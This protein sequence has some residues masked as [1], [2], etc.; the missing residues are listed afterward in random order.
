MEKE[1]I[2]KE[3]HKQAVDQHFEESFMRMQHRQIGEFKPTTGSAV[4]GVPSSGPWNPP[5]MAVKGQ[6]SQQQQLVMTMSG[7]GGGSSSQAPPS[8]INSQER[9]K[10]KDNRDRYMAA[11]NLVIDHRER[12]ARSSQQQSGSSGGPPSNNPYPALPRADLSFSVQGYQTAPSP[13]NNQMPRKTEPQQQHHLSAADYSK[14]SGGGGGVIVVP[15]ERLERDSMRPEHREQLQRSFELQQQQRLEGRDQRQPTLSYKPY[16]QTPRLVAGSNNS[17][18]GNNIRTSRSPHP[19]MTPPT[20]SASAYPIHYAG[21]GPGSS[22][23]PYSPNPTSGRSGPSNSYMPPPSVSPSRSPAAAAHVPPYPAMRYSP[24]PQTAPAP[25]TSPS[26]NQKKSSPSPLQQQQNMGPGAA[27]YGRQGVASAGNSSGTSVQCR[28][29][30]TIPLSLITPSK[31]NQPESAPPPAH[32]ARNTDRDREREIRERER[33]VR[34]YPHNAFSPLAHQLPPPQPLL[35]TSTN[36]RAGPAPGPPMPQQQPLDLGTY[37]EDSPI[38]LISSARLST[39]EGQAKKTRPE[40]QMQ[41][42]HHHLHQQQQAPP[43]IAMQS[44][45]SLGP[46]GFPGAPL[47]S[48]AALI[49]AGYPTSG[50]AQVK[51][52]SNAAS[53]FSMGLAPPRHPS[54]TPPL[55]MSSLP[56]NCNPIDR[57]VDITSRPVFIKSEPGV[58]MTPPLVEQDRVAVVSRSPPVVA[59]PVVKQEE[60]KVKQEPSS[61]TQSNNTTWNNPGSSSSSSAKPAV[62]VHKLKKA[63]IQRH[64]G[65]SFSKIYCRGKHYV[66]YF[67]VSG[68]DELVVKPTFNSVDIKSEPM[69]RSSPGPQKMARKATASVKGEINGYSSP[70]NATDESEPLGLRGGAAGG[71]RKPRATAVATK[72]K[73]AKTAAAAAVAMVSATPASSTGGSSSEGEVSESENDVNN[74][75]GGRTKKGG[76]VAALKET[77]GKSGGAGRGSV[78]GRQ[79]N[80]DSSSSSKEG[81]PVRKGRAG[82]GVSASSGGVVPA[83]GNASPSGTNAKPGLGNP[84]NK[85]PVPVLKKSGESFLQVRSIHPC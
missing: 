27:L 40:Q 51:P 71:K 50:T 13:S 73:R 31:T 54:D 23:H 44:Y 70:Q 11:Y 75:G 30:Q 37:R 36:S 45:P 59:A 34:I 35:N 55:L 64:T 1:R 53:A 7:G 58:E 76:A 85:P 19:Q 26:P 52:P 41:Q 2:E 14:P 67:H 12:V 8:H 47:M 57:P 84:F 48:V 9:D 3:R 6:T 10:D 28:P 18:G 61:V 25:C 22:Q 16:E 80:S 46:V 77:V 66:F 32:T 20:S 33:D 21:P 42:Q 60:V 65:T 79:R 15:N 72:D 49:D 78:A 43:Q 74:S 4:G 83:P 63:W 5:T 81:Q 38:P 39:G 29:D 62:H 17:G 69:D 68:G 56:L 82:G 24:A